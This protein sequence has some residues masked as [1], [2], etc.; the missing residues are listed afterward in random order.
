MDVSMD[1]DYV[2]PDCPNFFN[3]FHPFDPVAYR[4]EPL[5]D[6]ISASSHPAVL[7][8][9]YMRGGRRLHLSKLF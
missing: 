3:I 9:H 2:L 4:F 5:I 8:P 7:V 1:A 6:P